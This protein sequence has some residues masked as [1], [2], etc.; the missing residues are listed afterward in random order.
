[1]TAVIRVEGIE[2]SEGDQLAA[3]AESG[4]CRGVANATTMSDGSTLFLMTIN[5]DASE[6][7]DIALQRADDVKAVAKGAVTYGAN[8]TV[9]SLKS[10]MVIRFG[11][12]GENVM[13]YPTPFHSVL[14]IKA[15][16]DADA[17]V[18]VFVTDVAGARVAQWHDCNDNGSVN[19][20]WDVNDNIVVDG[21]YI[22]NVVINGKV[23]AIKTVK[24]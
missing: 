1:M 5:G 20:V 11:N 9:G 16:A 18:D 6:A 8:A 23:N 2:A 21:V 14:N 15:S 17:K 24:R 22:V 4:E 10:P 7:V 12:E 3:Y 13:V 19:I